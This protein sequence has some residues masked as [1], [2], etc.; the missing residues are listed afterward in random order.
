MNKRRNQ[1]GYTLVELIVAT[2]IMSL[3]IIGI[4]TFLVD[5]MVNN[6]VRT[7]KA[8][9]LREAQLALD[10]MVK[11]IRLSSHAVE[12]NSVP[13]ENSPDAV[14]TGGIGWASDAG[15]LV[16]DT[17]AEDADGDIIFANETNF[18]SEK[19]N[20]IYYVED[21]TLYK[22]TLAN[23]VDDNA[24]VTSCPPEEASTSCPAD[25]LSI[26]NVQSLVFKYYDGENNETD[27][28]NARSVEI[29]LNLHTV[30]YGRDVDVTYSTRTVFRNR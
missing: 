20:I 7:A 23:E 21:G 17:A 22:R 12:F 29:L 2:A 9:L 27:P 1:Y 3:L 14:A 4:M 28:P 30:K 10:V 6:S 11:D 16:L 24:A 26:K 15:T 19:N 18:I 8:D 5:T 25:R 13:D